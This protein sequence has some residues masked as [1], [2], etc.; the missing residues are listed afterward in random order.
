MTEYKQLQPDL[1]PAKKIFA[2][3]HFADQN[4]QSKKINPQFNAIMKK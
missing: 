2:D 3:L 4:L 1:N